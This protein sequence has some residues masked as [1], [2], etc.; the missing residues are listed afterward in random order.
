MLT[1]IIARFLTIPVKNASK[2]IELIRFEKN[3]HAL[4]GHPQVVTQK[5]FIQLLKVICQEA[6][7]KGHDRALL[8]D[9]ILDK[10]TRATYYELL[11]GIGLTAAIHYP[12]DLPTP[13]YA[14][15]FGSSEAKISAR[16]NFLKEDLITGM[17]LQSNQIYVLS[18]NRE[19]GVSVPETEAHSRQALQKLGRDLTEMK[20]CMLYMETMLASLE[21]LNKVLPVIVPIE[22]VTDSSSRQENHSVKTAD[23]VIPLKEILD[24]MPRTD[25]PILIAY[26]CQPHIL[27]QQQDAQQILGDNYEVVGVG[28]PLDW[29]NFNSNLTSIS[30]CCGEISRLIYL[31][32]LLLA[33]RPEFETRLTPGEEQELLD[34]QKESA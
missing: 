14:I 15:M 19:L 31:N 7:F 25:K 29:E 5:D 22:I 6:W 11:T 20:M 28:A 8:G 12:A 26:S 10:P 23:T 9:V 2:I 16:V 4:A 27:R 34:L 21:K 33:S 30:N 3:W 32:S 18:C 13:A 24:K 1:D 17:S